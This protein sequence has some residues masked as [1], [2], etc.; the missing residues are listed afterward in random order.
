MRK[1]AAIP[2]LALLL[3]TGCSAATE[4]A[5][6]AA[7][8]AAASATPA[9]SATTTPSATPTASA[10][11]SLEQSCRKLLGPEGKGVLSQASYFVRINEGTYGFNGPAESARTVEKQ[12]RSIALTAPEG[13][14]V[15]LDELV[16]SLGEAIIAAESQTGGSSFDMFAWQSTIAD[17]Q[18]TCAPYEVG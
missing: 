2:A 15:Q 9:P 12:I 16:S 17:L 10:K 14:D 13:L 5:E 8:P 18:A 7:A 4:A 3:L 11:D 1:T 6:P